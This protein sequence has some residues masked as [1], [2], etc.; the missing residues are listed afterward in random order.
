M[1]WIWAAIISGIASAVATSVISNMSSYPGILIEYGEIFDAWL[2][3][4]D[5]WLLSPDNHVFNPERF[6][7]GN[8]L[9]VNAMTNMRATALLGFMDSIIP[10]TVLLGGAI[11]L[12]WAFLDS[13]LLSADGAITRVFLALVTG[14][15][16]LSAMA[17]VAMYL[18]WFSI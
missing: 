17:L 10:F 6:P 9:V 3:G 15:G 16:S 8:E 13:L 18:Y 1:K 4:P 7:Q 12:S 11:Y 5:G 2:L 14:T